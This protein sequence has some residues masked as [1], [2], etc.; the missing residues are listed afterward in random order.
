MNAVWIPGIRLPHPAWLAP[1]L[2]PALPLLALSLHTETGQRANAFAPALGL[3]LLGAALAIG[4]PAWLAR[5]GRL[6]RKEAEQ[7]RPAW[8]ASL[9]LAPAPLLF[10][11]G[12]VV[13]AAVMFFVATCA[14]VAAVPF[15]MEFQQRTLG[16]LLSQPVERG[17]LWRI[18]TAVLTVAL[19]AHAA[20]FTLALGVAGAQPP[21]AWLAMIPLAVALALGTT[22]WWTL[23]TRSLIA[24]LVFALAVP[25]V[26]AALLALAVDFA[27]ADQDVGVAAQAER[28]TFNL[29]LWL[30]APLYAAAGAWLGRRRWLGLEAVEAD[31]TTLAGL[32]PRRNAGRTQARRQSVW[33]QL[34][35]KE[36]RLH[37]V[38]WAVCGLTVLLALIVLGRDWNVGTREAL[39]VFT[40]MLA[41]LTV[42]LAGATSIAEERRLG[43]LDGQLLQ[44]VS[45]ARQWWLKLLLAAVPA[46]VAVFAAVVAAIGFR[47]LTQPGEAA[48]AN[49]LIVAG[50]ASGGFVAAVLASSASANALRA[51]IAGLVI[52]F[53][54][55]LA[56]GG[57]MALLDLVQRD[58]I[59]QPAAET[60]RTGRLADGTDLLERAAALTP[61]ELEGLQS[62]TFNPE[63]RFGFWAGL[64]MAIWA[65]VLAAA[66]ACAW[67]NFVSP[68]GASG[69]LLRQGVVVIG[70]L[71]VCVAAAG[72]WML[73]QVAVA[74]ERG[75][76]LH[77]RGHLAWEQQL[78]PAQRELHRLR[79]T[80]VLHRTVEL[81]L[82]PAADA[83]PDTL[84]GRERR[85]LRG[86][87]T[88][89]FGLPLKPADLE[90]VLERA[91]LPDEKL[92][93]A[94]RREAETAR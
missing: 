31:D 68:A 39:T 91:V 42:L 66:L 88:H 34:A 9:F 78:S 36:L 16:G 22:P 45:R 58:T 76:L 10:G 3:F 50:F 73:R 15:G 94:L 62:P 70:V 83:P 24:G 57:T 86:G 80:G 56:I 51:L 5:A 13:P 19:L 63:D 33:L 18:K 21:P 52:F 6:W 74:Q 81:Y 82:K 64:G 30:A 48:M 11:G 59:F 29:A 7:L 26:A 60:W 90:N 75:L 37:A 49:L 27:T 84:P 2:L 79:R 92:R 25:L 54:G 14:V 8:L 46:G 20:A 67:R 32:F 23:L 4:V 1:L 85:L 55:A 93:E 35:G 61:A 47:G 69:R 12:D 77:A 41:A 40:A 43:T 28:W 65:V 44:P 53:A 71:V 89:Q 38:T 72:A 17:D 87:T